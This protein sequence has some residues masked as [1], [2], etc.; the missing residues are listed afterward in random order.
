MPRKP[1]ASQISMPFCM[2]QVAAVWRSA[3]RVAWAMP[4]PS[5]AEAKPVL[6]EVVIGLPFHSTK[7]LRDL[8]LLVGTGSASEEAE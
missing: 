5:T 1:A 6:T 4:A 2:S 7:K 3:C 8:A